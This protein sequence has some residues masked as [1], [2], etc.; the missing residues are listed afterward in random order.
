MSRDEDMLAMLEEK[1]VET[2]EV[3]TLETVEVRY[4]NR[5]T[6]KATVAINVVGNGIQLQTAEGNGSVDA[7]YNA[8]DLVT[9]ETVELD[10]YSIKSVTH[11]KDALGEVHVVLRQDDA[12]AQGRGVSTDILDAS[13]RAYVDALNRLIEKRK[14]PGRS[15]KMSLI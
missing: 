12:V 11:G 15:D 3:F 8:I 10:D 14:A 2:V 6:P 7:I 13:A 5:S 4:G 1:L 9:G